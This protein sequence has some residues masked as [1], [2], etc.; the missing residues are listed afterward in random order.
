MYMSMQRVEDFTDY[1]N[2]LNLVRMALEQ[3]LKPPDESIL[4]VAV[5]QGLREEFKFGAQL[6][7]TGA[8]DAIT[9]DNVV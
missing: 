3:L 9:L 5:I 7:S 4:V 1:E 8:M 6:L 2:R